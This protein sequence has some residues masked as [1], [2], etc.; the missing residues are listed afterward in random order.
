MGLDQSAP[1]RG[2]R[3]NKKNGRYP[4]PWIK[5]FQG[6][7]CWTQMLSTSWR[8]IPPRSVVIARG[9]PRRGHSRRST[10]LSECVSC[11]GSDV[12]LTHLQNLVSNACEWPELSQWQPSVRPYSRFTPPHILNAKSFSQ[13]QHH[14]PPTSSIIHQ[15]HPSSIIHHPPS[16]ET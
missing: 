9:S 3:E 7:F 10:R 5:M 12:R 16:P 11:I 13:Y 4:K 1:V 2:K 15:H 14:H 6:V 8:N